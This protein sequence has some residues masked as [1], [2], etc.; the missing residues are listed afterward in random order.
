M[1][2][3][4]T[5]CRPPC[6]GVV[7]GTLSIECVRSACAL[8]RRMHSE[9]QFSPSHLR[10]FQPRETGSVHGCIGGHSLSKAVSIRLKQ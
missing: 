1:E 6:R 4:V 2:S 3:L 5:G 7:I 9:A 10:R 8:E